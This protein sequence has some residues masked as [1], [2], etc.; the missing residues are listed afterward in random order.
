[1]AR[2]APARRSA[3]TPP[4]RPALEL[5]LL[6]AP[7]LVVGERR[8]ALSAKD[9]ALLCLVALAGPIRADRVAALLW[10]RPA[11]SRP[12]PACASASTAC[13]AS[14]G[15]GARRRRRPRA[16]RDGAHRPR[17]TP[18]ADRPRRARA[19]RALLGDLDFDALPEL[20]EWLREQRRH[21]HE[22]CARRSRRAAARCEAEGAVARGLAS[23]SAWS[24]SIRSPSMASAA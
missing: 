16:A 23:R 5:R 14:R 7:C 15:A 22:R 24:S 11:R 8:I 17:R 12:T 18:R 6:G 20:A 1:M 2:S 10:P 13:V 19:A 4:S 9:A 3:A 21:W